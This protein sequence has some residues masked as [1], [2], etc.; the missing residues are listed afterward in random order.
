MA[1]EERE[2]D[3]EEESSEIEERDL[4]GLD[5]D[6]DLI[7]NEAIKKDGQPSFIKEKGLEELLIDRG[8]LTDEQLDS[9]KAESKETGKTLKDILIESGFI[10]QEHM[11]ILL[12]VELGVKSVDL[13][14]FIIEPEIA[15]LVPESTVRKLKVL[16]LFKEGNSLTVAMAD[17]T[18]VRII[19]E[20]HRETSLM[21]EPVLASD[22]EI[23][24]TIDQTY[25]TADTIYEVVKGIDEKK[26]L[27]S[28][29]AG[30]EAP[31]VKLTNLLIVQAVRD[32][33]SDIHIEPEEKMVRV[34]YRIDG[35]LH[36]VVSLPKFLQMPI[37]SRIKIM[38]DLD[39]AERRLPQ[40]G[41]IRMDVG[42]KSIDLRVSL[43][44]TLFGENLVMR[45][46]DKS[47]I[48]IGIESLG[49]SKNDFNTF[50]DVVRTPH[51]MILVT[52]PTGSGKTTT[53]YS[54]INRINTEDRSIMTME[55]PTE[56]QIP[57]VRQTQVNPQIGLTYAAGLRAILRQDPDIIM[58][59]EV[60]D[61]ETAEIAIH[62]A[63]T[64]HLV[65]STL[66]TNDA[67][68]AFTRLIDMGVEAFLASSSIAAVIAQRLIR[69]I[70]ENCKKEHKPSE[71]ALGEL[72]IRDRD[73]VVFYEGVGCPLCKGTGYKGRIGIFS[74]LRSTSRIQELVVSRAPATDI[75]KVARSEGMNSLRED[76][77]D[78]VRKGVTTI[79]EMF[80]VTQDVVV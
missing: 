25:G 60:R 34:R 45:I 20:L 55:D 36:R 28:K 54:A 23:V 26:L 30:E 43:Q 59:G 67:A 42:N 76:C 57:L 44:P 38:A 8:L 39:I 72:G 61:L 48:M 64:G 56:Y 4:S 47:S 31:I 63:L 13:S 40:D 10:S 21:I 11:P 5:G 58:V 6:Q 77:L 16:P 75:D 3:S 24:R 78:K 79:E 71:A 66:H 50:A 29:E 49:F 2:L 37:T 32:R 12:G 53:L 69:V 62:A 70:C 52:G 46:L 9:V 22:M 27:S 33:A 68:S 73:N 35:V 18:D 17:P 51:G 80:R 41:R 74:I 14:S 19:D 65:F 7:L 1:E 15:A